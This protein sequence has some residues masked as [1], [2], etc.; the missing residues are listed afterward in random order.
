[1]ALLKE[2]TTLPLE[3]ISVTETNETVNNG[4]INKYLEKFGLN[5]YVEVNKTSVKVGDKLNAKW[6]IDGD[7]SQYGADILW[8]GIYTIDTDTEYNG[9]SGESSFTVKPGM[10]KNVGFKL[11]IWEEDDYFSNEEIIMEVVNEDGWQW[12]GDST[13]IILCG[14]RFAYDRSISAIIYKEYD[15]PTGTY[16]FFDYQWGIIDD[17]GNINYGQINK[18]ER[19]GYE[20]KVSF[21]PTTGKKGILKVIAYEY[22][23]DPYTLPSKEYFSDTFIISGDDEPEESANQV[24]VLQEDNQH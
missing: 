14:D 18:V 2:F 22:S 10:G 16:I 7:D 12:E 4:C 23:G 15:I 3:N 1:T 24:F 5:V 20:T 19:P 11:Q 8:Y 13:K 9:L 17:N 21:K 6:Y